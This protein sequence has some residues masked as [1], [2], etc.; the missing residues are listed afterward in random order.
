MIEYKS[1]LFDELER[2]VY[3]EDNQST[4]VVTDRVILV[5]DEYLDNLKKILN[6]EISKITML[7]L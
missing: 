3:N 1:E 2:I 5:V 7:D 6:T 4:G